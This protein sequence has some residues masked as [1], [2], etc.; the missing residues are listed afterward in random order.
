MTSYNEANWY[1]FIGSDTT[2]VWSSASNTFVTV[3]DA[4]YLTWLD[5]GG[6]PSKYNSFTDLQD[7]LGL[8]A[9]ACTRRQCF[10]QLAIM[11]VITETE[12]IAAIG[13]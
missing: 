4:T 3:S 1:W 7:G 12:A 13:T 8:V 2:Q 9:P 10:Q 5:D 6:T 11:S